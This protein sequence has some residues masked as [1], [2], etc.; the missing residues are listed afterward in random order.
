MFMV[1]RKE[2]WSARKAL[3]MMLVLG[4]SGQCSTHST[5]DFS[6]NPSFLFLSCDVQSLLSTASVVRLSGGHNVPWE[7]L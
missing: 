2:L 5:F 1:A 7:K 3:E 4:G 6:L